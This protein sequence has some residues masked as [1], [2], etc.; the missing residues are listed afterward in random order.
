MKKQLIARI[1]VVFLL[2]SMLS[3]MVLPASAA[4]VTYARNMT[5]ASA[6]GTYYVATA[7]DLAQIAALVN[8]G[9]TMKG[10]TFLQTQDIDLSGVDYT[11]I[12]YRNSA[13]NTTYSF[14]GTYDGQCH[15]ILNLNY[16]D[17]NRDGAGLIGSAYTATLKNI[18][19]ESGSVTAANRAGGV[20]GYADG[21]TVTNCYNKANIT[22]LSGTDGVGGIA[23]VARSSSHFY[24]CYNAGTITC[25]TAGAGGI[26][27]WGGKG[28]N[29]MLIGCYNAGALKYSGTLST[30]YY[31]LD[32]IAR[33]TLRTMGDFSS[34]YYLAGIYLDAEGNDASATYNNHNAKRLEKKDNLL[35]A[36]VLNHA[37]G[38]NTNAFAV[39]AK[40]DLAFSA[41]EQEGAV[42][43]RIKAIR[44][45]VLL[46]DTGVVLTS[47]G[48]YTVPATYG[49]YAVT[50]A[51][52]GG[53]SYEVGAFIP[54]LTANALTVTLTLEGTYP[55]VA[56]YASN[57]K[58]TV[59]TVSTVEELATLADLVDAGNTFAGKTVYVT[60][61]LDFSGYNTWNGIGHATGSGG[62][63]VAEGSL[64]FSGTF[65]GQF[66]HF[67]NINFRISSTY[68]GIFAH[69]GD[70]TIR[71]I[72]FDEGTIHLTTKTGRL[73]GILVGLLSNT[74]VENI[75]NHVSI[76]AE[77]EAVKANNMGLVAMSTND[78]VISNAVN[79]G[80]VGLAG[81]TNLQENGSFV[82]WGYNKTTIN[83]CIAVGAVAGDG[84]DAL[85]RG[86]TK[87]NCY[88]LPHGETAGTMTYD[89]LLSGEA[90]NLLNENSGLNI[91]SKGEEGPVLDPDH[92]VVAANYTVDEVNDLFS[93]TRVEYVNAGEAAD[94]PTY[95][96][97]TLLNGTKKFWPLANTYLVPWQEHDISLYYSHKDYTITYALNGG[98]FLV[99]PVTV[100]SGQAQ[101]L[102]TAL[103]IERSGYAFAG[104]Y[105]NPELTGKPVTETPVDAFH[106]TTYYAAWTTMKEISTAK[107]F[108]AMKANGNYI[109]TADIDMTGVSFTPVGSYE[110]PFTG[111][112]DGDGHTVS[113]LTI[114]S[115]ANYQGVVGVNA[116]V[117]RNLVLDDDCTIAGNAYVGGIAGENLGTIENCISRAAVSGASGQPVVSF[118]MLVQNMR[119]ASDPIPTAR[120][121]AMKER[122]DTCDADLMI[123]QEA[124]TP[125]IN[126]LTTNYVNTG[127]YGMIYK[128]RSTYSAEAV[129]VLY[130]KSKF[131][132]I[133]SGNF[134]LSTTPDV[135]S[136]PEGFT[137][138]RICSWAMLKDKTTSK[139][140]L[141]FSVHLDTAGDAVRTVN[142][143]ALKDRFNTIR[144][145]Y[146]SYDPVCIIAGDFNAAVGT[147]AYNVLA[148][149]DMVNT[150]YEITPALTPARIDHILISENNVRASDKT[151]EYLP[152]IDA[153]N[154]VPSDHAGLY[155]KMLGLVESRIG[156]IAGS[157]SG[158]ISSCVGET[159]VT[160]SYNYGTLTGRNLGAV[161]NAY[162]AKQTGV[163][164][165]GNS[166]EITAPTL[167]ESAAAT[168]YALNSASKVDRFT[169][170]S[171]EIDLVADG[172]DPACATA[173]GTN[174]SHTYG[175]EKTVAATCVKEGYKTK[176]CSVCK[177][178][179]ITKTAD[180]LGHSF[181][182]KTEHDELYHKYVCTTCGD[183]TYEAHTF[184]A[185]AVEATCETY[186]VTRYS[187]T[188]GYSYD[189]ITNDRLSHIWGDYAQLDA[190]QH[191]QLCQRDNA[192]VLKT[193]HT[194]TTTPVA[195]TCEEKGGNHYS[196]ADCGY[197]EYVASLDPLGHSY[198][199]WTPLNEEKHQAACLN[200][201]SHVTTAPHSMALTV[202]AP[203]CEEKGYNRYACND[204]G[205]YY[206]T[207]FVAA[208]GHTYVYNAEAQA[209]ICHC[210]GTYVTDGD[211]D[212]DGSAT[213]ADI[214]LLL[215]RID[216]WPEEIPDYKAD[217]NGDGK[218]RIFD[219]VR[220][221]QILN[222]QV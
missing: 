193:A 77:Q 67:K 222:T 3:C 201:P 98:Q 32:V 66:H 42:E 80:E 83:N 85:A 156:G 172:E 78:S 110:T 63:V 28:D 139:Y 159:T 93:E 38:V 217:V 105:T 164:P 175:K 25:A 109:L 192:H 184:T 148:S 107:Q 112:L 212:G 114:S 154:Y 21:C 102:P 119:I 138:Y 81:K 121:T 141:A 168:A 130:K 86:S 52:S 196:C 5:E 200:D 131:T 136:A 210:G 137:H 89:T 129:P 221:L 92:P 106:E 37:T 166:V 165:L 14:Y 72:I 30:V 43:L 24:G 149:D 40:G 79:Y 68:A 163:N 61:D 146:A 16:Y 62:G 160:G 152:V 216:G 145:K 54:S 49:S 125:W 167:M 173:S 26:V 169:V 191:Q 82:G 57:Q 190:N 179:K 4:G 198:G 124:N 100:I 17:E 75:E 7:A 182:D 116:G 60:A 12:G 171:E 123:L 73:G 88:Y 35:M 74:K 48:G 215:R 23:G 118:T 122:M 205:Y 9:M 209:Y 90:A 147:N 126:F 47:G 219:A 115:T 181:G 53:A 58:A 186:G 213:T 65:D 202:V 177:Y 103:E 188:C 113:G 27:G 87:T 91:W 36:Y 143:Q 31:A 1:T 142:A 187:C 208:L 170:T 29:S 51:K 10:Y 50:G 8:S 20:A 128:Y 19:I 144:A 204:C 108:A 46:E 6:K 135:E 97:Y 194:L 220:F 111:T 41:S 15:K 84:S 203:T 153:A 76:Y 56:D 199:T 96:G 197:E 157:N 55:S 18:G 13:A 39:N 33:N 64:P 150:V 207:D 45:G 71:N 162:Y 104:W 176:T 206:D 44:D 161:T 22:I 185:T 69:A 117:I 2:L 214:V 120:E 70:A 155:V 11:P 132:L 134:W 101:K 94:L 99:D 151:F 195:P 59:F 218:I 127:E 174:A 178:E 133:E 211:L 189:E 183:A 158:T 180:A 34:C 140:V 95:P